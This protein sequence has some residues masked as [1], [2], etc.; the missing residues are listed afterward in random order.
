MVIGT[1]TNFQK[2][3]PSTQRDDVW[4]LVPTYS[5]NLAGYIQGYTIQPHPGQYDEDGLKR[6][7]LILKTAAD[8]GVHLIMPLVN[9]EAGEQPF[10]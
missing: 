3:Y 5:A 10:P 6:M 7:D 1:L 9:F 2:L 8:Y 4:L